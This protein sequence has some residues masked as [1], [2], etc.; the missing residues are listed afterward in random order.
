MPLN[1]EKGLARAS[2]S[3]AFNAARSLAVI[4]RKPRGSVHTNATL[5]LA[6][7]SGLAG[8]LEL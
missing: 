6:E 2:M 3:D 5:I 8:Q 1:C 4:H 7:L